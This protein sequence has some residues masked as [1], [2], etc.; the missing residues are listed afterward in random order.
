MQN[1]LISSVQNPKIK[2]LKQVANF[3]YSNLFLVE[4]YHL[5]QEAF[6]NNLVI[7]TFELNENQLVYPNSTLITSNVLTSITNTKT[8][9]GIV[10]LCKISFK[11]ELN[12]KIIFLDNVQDPGN[13]GTI[14]RTMKAFNFNS[15]I[16]NIN[17]LNHKIIRSTQGAIFDLNYYQYKQNDYLI[18]KKLKSEGYKII[19]TLLDK[20]SQ[21][22]F[23]N[24][25][26][27]GK[28]VLI[29]GNEG[30]GI[31]HELQQLLDYSVYIP[32]DFESLNVAVA[33][34]IV[35]NHIYQ[36]EKK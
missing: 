22:Y 13:I 23:K 24:D 21:P 3:K 10:A 33:T 7:E 9:E 34:G 28:F 26:F 17:L 27:T 29:M 8:P 16:A 14:I 35:L 25:L 15:L 6:K 19:G 2:Y 31:S 18:I 32:I 12:D 36:S 5:V 20:N 11:T 4:G 1:K 30:N